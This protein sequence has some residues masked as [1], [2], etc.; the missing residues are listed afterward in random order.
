MK[1]PQAKKLKSGE[2]RIQLR[3]NGKS[4]C[5]LANSEKECKRKAQLIK[6]QYLN[7]TAKKKK[8]EKTDP[9]LGAAI[10]AYIEKYKSVL[11][12]STVRNY[13]SFRKHRFPN[14]IDNKLSKID[15]QSMIDDE[16]KTK[17]PKT[18]KNGWSLVHSTL[19]M[20]NFPIPEVR[21]A[22]VPEN[23]LPFLQPEE[24]KPFCDAIKGDIAEIGILLELQGLR[25]SEAKGLTWKNVSLSKGTIYV[26]DARVQGPDSKFVL[27]DTTKNKSSTRTIP[28]M[29]PQLE[30]ALKAEKDKTGPVV[31]VAENTL[32]RHCKEACKRAGVTICGNHGLRRSFASLGYHLGL[33][34]RDLMRLGGWS[35]WQTL[36]RVYI[37]LATSRNEAVNGKIKEFYREGREET[38]AQ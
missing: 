9:T 28:I 13:M 30:E 11:S 10:D 15:W 2:W 34:E 21:L 36:H 16:L 23:E 6:A 12:P 33:T 7:D 3:L 26:H 37:K 24:I 19:K 20:L 22:P 29:I 4:V 27:K 25:R 1:I 38:T 5:I 8:E 35:D 18:V 17:T 14:Y 32:L 31:K